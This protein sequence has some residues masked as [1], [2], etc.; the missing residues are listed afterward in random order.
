MRIGI[1]KAH[2]KNCYGSAGY[3]DE[4]VESRNLYPKVVEL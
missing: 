2:T 3:I 1:R 4:W